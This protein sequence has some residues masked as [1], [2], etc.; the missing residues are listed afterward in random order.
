MRKRFLA[1]MMAAA[2]VLCGC[3][4]ARDVIKNNMDRHKGY[5]YDFIDYIDISVIGV[6]GHGYL[7]ITPKTITVDQFESE[8]EFMAVKKD[9]DAMKLHYT[10][11]KKDGTKLVISKSTELSNSEKI[12]IAVS[13]KQESLNSDMNITP[14]AYT[15]EGLVSADDSAVVDLFA[16]ENVVFFGTDNN[17][18][19]YE[20][21]SDSPIADIL[22]PVEFD[23]DTSDQQLVLN[24]TIVTAKAQLN[25]KMEGMEDIDVFLHFAKNNK[26]LSTDTK[27]FVLAD[28]VHPVDFDV[29][30]DEDFSNMEQSLKNAI[31]NRIAKGN[32]TIYSIQRSN[33]NTDGKN[34]S[35]E[36]TVTFSAG[37]AEAREY[38]AISVKVYPYEG[39]FICEAGEGS[40]LPKLKPEDVNA[41]PENTILHVF[42]N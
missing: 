36:Y 8:D 38:S 14:Y 13:Y 34:V 21:R 37:T 12:S 3:R 33:R 39:R 35:Y 9:L 7:Y 11:E 10:P 15:V 2:C 41:S 42:N 17:D 22:I 30:T 20:K 16:P 40:Y 23:I 5:K 31:S 6:D 4:S 28:I 25:K 32:I 26:L 1:L 29:L 24:N 27:E 18:V 19:F